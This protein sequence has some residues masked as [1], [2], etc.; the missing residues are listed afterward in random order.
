MTS[1]VTL[2]IVGCGRLAESGY[3]PA[4]A[5]VSGARVVAVVDPDTTR[6]A[7]I[8]ELSGDGVVAHADLQSL[9]D[10]D[11]PDALVL[12][13]PVGNHL[14][15]ATAASAAGVPALL[16]KP[17]APDAATA[18]AISR[19]PRPPWIGFN[20]RFDPRA[21][22]ARA[23]LG[24]H[25][26]LE[27]EFE[28]SY[29]RRRWAPVQVHDDALLDLGPHLVDWARWVTGAEVE[30]VRTTE[31]RAERAVVSVRT[32]RGRASLVAATDTMYGERIEARTR[33]GARI[34][35]QR[36]GGLVDAVRGR[37]SGTEHPLV[38][39]LAAELDEFIRVV[40]GAAPERLGTAADGCAV[41]RVIDAAKVSA[42]AGGAPVAVASHADHRET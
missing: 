18:L 41:M 5:R 6:R 42:A 23:D 13:T 38:A 17:P 3:L 16:E 9:L 26:D 14:A 28:I 34:T 33:T 37:L 20:R 19:L 39:T 24:D 32:S 15:D 36:R 30:Q 31:L 2:G 11:P 27:L 10:T 21:A 25:D 7:R 12:A 22:Q 40:R 4:L 35:R 1:E 8:A 29:R